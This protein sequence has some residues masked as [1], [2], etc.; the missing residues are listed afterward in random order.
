MLGPD[1]G[2]R[3][4]RRRGARRGRADLL[5]TPHPLVNLRTLDVQSFRVSALDGSLSM[6]VVAAL[7]LLPLLFQEVF[8]WS[9]VRSGAVVLFVFVGNIGVKPARPRI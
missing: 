3:R 2:G 8:G 6:A 5:R 7:L 4:A 1:G 9:A